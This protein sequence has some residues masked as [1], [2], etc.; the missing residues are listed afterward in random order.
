MANLIT[1]VILYLEDKGKTIDESS[2]DFRFT[3][4]IQNDSDGKGDYL[5]AWND[6]SIAEPSES[7]LNSFE[8]AAN[9]RESLKTVQGKRKIEYLGLTEQLDLLYKDMLADK[10]D[11]TGDWFAAVKKVKDD[12]PKP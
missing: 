12:N 6:K 1:K 9:A 5:K 8:S 3:Y 4:V 2:D 11:K 7:T 10:G